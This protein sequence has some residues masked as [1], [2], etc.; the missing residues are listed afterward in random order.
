MPLRLALPLLFLTLLAPAARSWTPQTGSFSTQ[1]T[2]GFQWV[3]S[4][5]VVSERFEI[6][7]HRDYLD[8]EHE[9]EIAARGGWSAPQQHADK[10]EIIGKITLEKGASV[11]GILAW[12]KDLLLKGKLKPKLEARKQYEEVVDRNVTAPP[13]PRDP[14]LLEK[15]RTGDAYDLSI[16]PIQWGKSRKIRIRYL[17]PGR[18]GRMAYPHAFSDNATALVKPGPGIAGFRIHSDGE[19]SEIADAPVRLQAPTYNLQYQYWQPEGIL[20]LFLEPQV[21]AKPGSR[22]MTGSFTGHKFQGHMAHW[23]LR[24][25]ADLLKGTEYNPESDRILA[26]LGTVPDTCTV[27]IPALPD[28]ANGE[29]DIR[30]FHKEAPAPKIRWILKRG[31]A[32]VR[33]LPE[34]AAVEQAQDGLL[35]AR[36]FGNV[37]F[38]PMASV[39]PPSVGLALGLIDARYSLVAL[40][41]DAIAP[42]DAAGYAAGGVP[43]LLPADIFPAANEAYD[44]PLMSWLI[45]R[46]LTRDKLL[47]ATRV[48]STAALPAGL[49][50]SVREG[51]LRVEIDPALR[52][53]GQSLE[54]SVHDMSGR[55]LRAWKAGDLSSGAITWSP[56]AGSNASAT[57]VIKARMG[58][59]S[60]S[61]I[62]RI[63]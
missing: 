35:Y 37:P 48:A 8:V 18:E 3:G 12:Y 39:M 58:G 7:V 23:F 17:I 59:R 13:P 5:E 53:Q 43:T 20:P 54:L 31:S 25:P 28:T 22:V 42:A 50:I 24:V 52:R 16:F 27:A 41:Q 14:V 51:M 2:Q 56:V 62:I 36:S 6:T 47:Q 32:A 34:D 45:E 26:T 21:V 38:F 29:S 44:Q 15:A 9:L 10:L 63:P 33:T 11:V 1:A 61:R 46:G 60:W 55:M 4:A 49:R 40:E 30:V 57:Y 19:R